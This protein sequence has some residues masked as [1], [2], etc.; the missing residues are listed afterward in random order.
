MMNPA[1]TSPVWCAIAVGLGLAIPGQALPAKEP[2]SLPVRATA[3]SRAQ[4]QQ[5]PNSIRTGVTLVPINIR[6]LDEEGRP[7]TDLTREDFHILEDGVLQDTKQF[8][9]F[10]ADASMAE[11]RTPDEDS[12]T[13]APLTSRVFLLVLGRG[14]LVGP[15][16]ELD[17]LIE[18]S[19]RK[20]LSQDRVAVMAYNRA[21]PFVAEHARIARFLEGYKARHEEIEGLLEQ[22]FSGLRA[23]FG[24][25]DIPPFIQANID[26]LFEDFKDRAT[27]PPPTGSS[28]LDKARR[29]ADAVSDELQRAALLA[30]RNSGLPDPGAA[31]TAERVGL[32]FDE[33]VERTGRTLWDMANAYKGIEY[34]HYVGGE[35]HL[36]FI[37]R[38]GLFL[39]G[40]ER[41][42][43][44]AAAA[45]DARV[46]FDILYTGGSV[47]APKAN[48]TRSFAVPTSSQVFEQTFAISDLRTFAQSTGGQLTAFR[49]GEHALNRL[50]QSTRFQY[51]LAY[52][53]HIPARDGRFRRLDVRVDRPGVRV[54]FRHGYYARPTRTGFD[55]KGILTYARI[56]SAGGR[57]LP[58]RE[59]EVAAGASVAKT[60]DGFLVRL[61]LTIAADRLALSEVDG[62]FRGAL[63]IAVFCG[64]ARETVVCESWQTM[65]LNLTAP[66]HAR[67]LKDGIP[68]TLT[69]SASAPVRYV[70]VV[71]YDYAADRVGSVT[72]EIE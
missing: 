71:V 6:V 14:R 44:L 53:P 58:M 38:H 42:T 70:K 32:G 54:L 5:P 40:L 36:L 3:E 57:A 13:I 29:D 72:V 17:A 4:D 11:A 45:S 51:L 26:A 24:S 30:D 61:Q 35:K 69:V 50:D 27:T 65:D 48:S 20:L 43:S 23:R 22:W 66:T 21:T 55:R 60:G 63:D 67:M 18:F 7:V 52:E 25:A 68:R 31:S 39:P 8:L 33:Y 15:S 64:D 9:R 46:T 16:K 34:L 1:C 19:R 41:D 59:I 2:S 62:R 56:A 47:G 10:S 49:S 37:T 28:T 12:A